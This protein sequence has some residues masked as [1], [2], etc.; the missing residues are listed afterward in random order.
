MLRLF[1]PLI[2]SNFSKILRN[3]TVNLHMRGRGVE[4]SLG[5][6]LRIFAVI[7]FGRRDED[8]VMFGREN[9]VLLL[10]TP[11]EISLPVEFWGDYWGFGWEIL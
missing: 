3:A 1:L 7:A 10:F 8:K 11:P 2:F 9:W 5:A 4:D 6:D